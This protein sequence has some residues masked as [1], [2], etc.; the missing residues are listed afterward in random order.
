VPMIVDNKSFRGLDDPIFD[1]SEHHTL[2]GPLLTEPYW[3]QGSHSRA[4]SCPS[5]DLSTKVVH[6]NHERI[7]GRRKSLSILNSLRPA[8]LQTPL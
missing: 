5:P 2:P 6:N 4:C 7:F 8:P 1:F 3:G